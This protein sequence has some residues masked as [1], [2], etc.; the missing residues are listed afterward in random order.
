[1]LE[2]SVAIFFIVCD[3]LCM[4]GCVFDNG[5]AKSPVL[6]SNLMILL[7]I[8]YHDLQPKSN[9]VL[10]GLLCLEMQSPLTLPYNLSVFLAQLCHNVCFVSR[11]RWGFCNNYDQLFRP[12]NCI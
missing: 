9:D 11:I 2:V 5:D 7:R 1:M 3:C 8:S 6:S 4:H 12:A 10:L